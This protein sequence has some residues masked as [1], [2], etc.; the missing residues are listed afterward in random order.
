VALIEALALGLPAIASASGG[1]VDILTPDRTG[2]L[3]APED[4]GDLAR[5]LERLLRGAVRPVAPE[6]IRDSV[7]E[8]RAAAVAARYHALYEQ[9]RW[10]RGG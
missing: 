1:N 4:A 8:R 10:P 3:F 9:V 6:R 2:V 7:R 5:Q